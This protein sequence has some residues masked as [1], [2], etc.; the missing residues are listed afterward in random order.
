MLERRKTEANYWDR[1]ATTYDENIERI[2]GK[3]LRR[4][5]V[6]LL[7]NERGL[8]DA[9][10]LGCGTGYFTRVIA[11]NATHVTATDLSRDMLEVAK[12]RLG[13]FNNVSFQVE[14]SEATSF[15]SE[16]FD[17]A[18]MANMLHTLDDPLKALMEC[19]RVLKRGGTLLILNYT[20]QGMGRVERTF[21]RFRFAIKFGFPPRKNWPMTEEKLRLLL[22]KSGFTI[23]RLDLIKGKINTFYIRSRKG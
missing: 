3:D 6:N 9:V 4:N 11:R 8:G 14:N 23:E 7:E 12:A 21:M 22:E 20:D 15:Q 10:E 19:H 17:T 18:L 2:F 1:F 13:G 16:S 5:L